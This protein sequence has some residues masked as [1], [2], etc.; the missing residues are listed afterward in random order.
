MMRSIKAAIEMPVAQGVLD[1]RFRPTA[2]VKEASA[3]LGGQAVDGI[4]HGPLDRPDPS[5][6]HDEGTGGED[7]QAGNQHDDIAPNSAHGMSPTPS[8][9]LPW[10]ERTGGA[11][12][13]PVIGVLAGQAPAC[14]RT[15]QAEQHDPRKSG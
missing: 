6:G 5:V 9:R 10:E 15:S 3:R 11:I 2:S 14:D 8:R 12:V 13:S 7:R 1:Q 4:E